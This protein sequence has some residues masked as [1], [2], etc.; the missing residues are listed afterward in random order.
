MAYEKYLFTKEENIMTTTYKNTNYETIE[1]LRAALNSELEA[2]AYP[3]AVK[4]RIYGE[5][6]LTFVKAP[7]LGP[8]LYATI[9]FATATKTFSL[10]VALASNMLTMPDGLTDILVEAQSIYKAA[11][12]ESQNEQRL[13]EQAA[14]AEALEAKKKAAEEQKAEEKYQKQKAKALKDFANRAQTTA[15]VNPTEE[16]YYSLGWLTKHAGTIAAVLPDYLADAFAKHFGPEAPCRIVDSK[17]RSPAGWQ[18]QWS[19]SFTV[20]L[21]KPD[22]IPATIAQHLNTDGNKVSDTSFVW[23]LVDNYGFQFGKTQDVD[24]IRSHVPASHLSFFEAG[25]A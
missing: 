16:F 15:V 22:V 6:Q 14:R 17:K 8:A 10:D 7:L 5:G 4:H 23:D 3:Y 2:L 21:K 13:V 24:K 11:V 19:W 20:S 9:D 25:L 1:D 18:Q 12:I